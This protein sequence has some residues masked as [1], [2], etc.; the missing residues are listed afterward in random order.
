MKTPTFPEIP[1]VCMLKIN[2]PSNVSQC[3]ACWVINGYDCHWL[4]STFPWALS[5]ATALPAFW[6]LAWP[7]GV[8]HRCS[9][10]CHVQMPMPRIWDRR[11]SCTFPACDLSNDSKFLG[12]TH[13]SCDSLH[14]LGNFFAKNSGSG[15]PS[16]GPT[17]PLALGSV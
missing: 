1:L 15:T 12:K 14:V 6:P 2:I 3:P 11:G 5:S 10:T 13:N 4:A 16:S 7:S 17:K 9:I 8:R